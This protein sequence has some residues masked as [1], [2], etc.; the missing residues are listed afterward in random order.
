PSLGTTAPSSYSTLGAS[1]CTYKA[2]RSGNTV[3]VIINQATKP[4]TIVGNAASTFTVSSGSNIS[5]VSMTRA[6]CST[7]TATVSATF[8]SGFYPQFSYNSGTNMKISAA[9][10][11]GGI[12]SV[13]YEYTFTTNVLKITFSGL[14]TGYTSIPTLALTTH[15]LGS[16]SL[17]INVSNATYEVIYEST[18]TIVNVTP[19]TNYYITQAYVGSNAAED[20]KYY[21]GYLVQTANAFSISYETSET[22]SMVK[23]IIKDM[24]GDLTLNVVTGNT[25][26][27]LKSTGG[28]GVDTVAIIA[29]NGGEA[30]ITGSD[31]TDDSDTVVCMAVAYAGY[32]FVGWTD[33]DGNNLGTT[34]NI[35]L[36]KEQAEGKLIT[37][38]FAK[39][40]ANVNTETSN[41]DVLV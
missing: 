30:R 5:A 11:S 37:A 1:V 7:T 27:I 10:G 36:T 25:K 2:Y 21:R 41:T 26:P 14:P 32:E 23:F 9:A 33:S 24:T 8:G 39:I 3:I 35:R 12:G 6:T 19:S 22:S 29:T 15:T 20:V 38:N 17:V 34:L 40:D 4:I 16:Y 13:S 28:V 31:L 18:Q